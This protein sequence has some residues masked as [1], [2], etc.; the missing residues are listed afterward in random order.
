MVRIWAVLIS[1][2][3]SEQTGMYL[4]KDSF[5]IQVLE[6]AGLDFIKVSN[7]GS[8][9]LMN[10]SWSCLRNLTCIAQGME[11]LMT[12]RGRE[13]ILFLFLL[14]VD[15]QSLLGST[16]DYFIDNIFFQCPRFHLSREREGESNSLELNNDLRIRTKL[17][18]VG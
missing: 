7:E 11:A 10:L 13:N 3:L 18:N 16:W 5:R 4:N 1:Q 14:P 8:P 12:G 17:S 15:S 6:N 9:R 2:L